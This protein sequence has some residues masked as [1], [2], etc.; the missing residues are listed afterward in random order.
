MIA[1]IKK[2]NRR[3][4]ILVPIVLTFVLIQRAAA[5]TKTNTSTKKP[6][7]SIPNRTWPDQLDAVAAAPKNHQVVYEDRHV[8]VLQVICPPGSEEPVH[9]HRYKSTMWFTHSARFIYY[10]Y[11]TSKNGRLVKKDSVEVKGFPAEALTKGQKVD[12]EGLH[13]VKNISTDTLMA[14]RVEYKEAFKK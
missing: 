8:R 11:V 5:Q 14:Y 6:A 2:L 12:R 13:S 9:T 3:A 7:T 10:T 4:Q 1:T